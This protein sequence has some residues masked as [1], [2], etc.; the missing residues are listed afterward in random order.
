M[1]LEASRVREGLHAK[2]RPAPARVVSCD[3]PAP[4]DPQVTNAHRECHRPSRE[5]PWDTAATPEHPGR[6]S[7][8][9]AFVT[10][11]V[12][13]GGLVVQ[14]VSAPDQA[15]NWKRTRLAAATLQSSLPL[16]VRD[17]QPKPCCDGWIARLPECGCQEV[18]RRD[19]IGRGAHPPR[20]R[21]PPAERADR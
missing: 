20:S 18:V 13:T 3:M 14:T 5:H 1:L 21:G 8:R 6:A 16:R 9:R 7:T 11:A 10:R 2:G 4:E 15:M 17:M 19:S 12:S